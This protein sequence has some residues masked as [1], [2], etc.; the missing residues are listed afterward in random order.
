MPTLLGW[1]LLLI[2]VIGILGNS[3]VIFALTT[4]KKRR[5]TD[6]LI[7]NLAFADL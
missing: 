4:V 5:V 7:L 6:N 1:S 2:S 3:I